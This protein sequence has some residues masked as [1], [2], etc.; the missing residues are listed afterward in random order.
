[1]QQIIVMQA[2]P[3]MMQGGMGAEGYTGPWQQP[4]A[5]PPP[6]APPSCSPGQVPMSAG[7][8]CQNWPNKQHEAPAASPFPMPLSPPVD[9]AF[10]SAPAGEVPAYFENWGS[11][12]HQ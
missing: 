9:Q 11:E 10:Y 1:M 7:G 2:P 4:C 12:G 3:Q 8:P 5:P 6:C